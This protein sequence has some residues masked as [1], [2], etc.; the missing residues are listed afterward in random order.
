MNLDI[1]NSFV[2]ATSDIVG[3]QANVDCNRREVQIKECSKSYGKVSG[4]VEIQVSDSKGFYVITFTE[5]LIYNLMSDIAG[6]NSK[7]INGT[8]KGIVNEI[9]YMVTTM[10][11]SILQ[12]KGFSFNLDM[13]EV[14]SGEDYLINHVNK[15]PV[16]LVPY[17]TSLG[18]FFIEM[19]FEQM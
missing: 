4:I 9:A 1:I 11:K 17:N 5:Q 16:I 7:A 18:D 15:A 3:T 14:L 13:P 10:A 6:D 8:A 2:T 19:Y 12:R